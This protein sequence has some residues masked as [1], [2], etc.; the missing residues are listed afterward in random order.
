MHKNRRTYIK[1]HTIVN[2]NKIF[3]EII[4]VDKKAKAKQLKFKHILNAYDYY[5]NETIILF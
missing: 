3:E 2:K 4:N 5:N 1:P